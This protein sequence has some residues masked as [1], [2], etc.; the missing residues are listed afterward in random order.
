[1]MKSLHRLFIPLLVL[2][3]FA[4]SSDDAQGP[5]ENFSVQVTTKPV[6]DITA[7]TARS[8]GV[9]TA[10]NAPN[11]TERG[12]CWS[13]TSSP[14]VADAKT[15]DGAGLGEYASTLSGLTTGDTYYVRAYAIAGSQTFYGAAVSFTA[16]A[17]TPAVT[18]AEVT[19]IAYRTAVCGGTIVDEGAS[20][21]TACGICWSTTENPT[22]ESDNVEGDP[23]EKT[24]TLPME[25]LS[26]GT[27]YYVRA[28]ASNRAGTGYGEQMRFSTREESLVTIA[29]EAFRQYC[30]DRFDADYDGKLQASEAAEVTEIDCSDLGI[31]S[32]EGIAAFTNLRT[33][34][35]NDNPL[36]EIDVTAN[37]KL[38]RLELIRTGF[39]S[40]AIADMPELESLLCDGLKDN[41][42][43]SLQTLS[44]TGC[45]ALK[46]LFCQENSLRTLTLSNTPALEILRFNTN[47]LVDLDLS[48]CP[49]LRELYGWD[50]RLAALDL[51]ANKALTS[52]ELQRNRLTS[53]ELTDM[54]ELQHVWCDGLEKQGE[55]DVMG[56]LR[57]IR[58]ANCPKLE[59]LNCQENSLETLV[60]E[61]CPG[62]IRLGAWRNSLTSLDLTGCESLKTLQV[63]DNKL[64]G[65]TLAGCASLDLLDI[66]ENQL[67][68]L[69]LKDCVRLREI[70]L[71]G[72]R[73]LTALDLSRNGELQIF[74]SMNTGIRELDLSGHAFLT[75]VWCDGCGMER[76]RVDNCPALNELKCQSNALTSL[77]VSGCPKLGVLWADGNNLSSLDLS[78]CTELSECNAQ[79]N[80]PLERLNVTG[81]TGLK[82]L[83]AWDCGLLTL[84]LSTN[85]N[86]ELVQVNDNKLTSLSVRGSRLHD[87]HCVRNA[88]TSFTATD[89]PALNVIW[90]HDN[91]L[92]TLDVS[93]CAA[94]MNILGVCQPAEPEA[95]GNPLQTLYVAAGQTFA[96]RYI[97]STTNIVIR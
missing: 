77:T 60:L 96:E 51:S 20:E 40:L 47:G 3:L 4:C 94:Q 84:D 73:T 70:W 72:N 7:T 45:P 34:M 38:T 79:I 89:C 32:L 10:E 53:L 36:H 62:L 22:I 17:A 87:V 61:G 83:Q 48:G 71:Q 41:E 9:L 16:G 18:T 29:D 90:I 67:A 5:G 43:G 6:T 28:F 69:D 57:S 8:G 59:E 92:T 82:T 24:F 21:V 14:T 37:T 63:A 85:E 56:T 35:A 58:I 95:H 78:G 11:V 80:K 15:S 39:A 76:I 27:T 30:L 49:A 74:R 33:L 86:L 75:S 50:N 12:V 65:L 2:G 88:L 91:Q 44:I 54:P 64:T 23:A 19:E 68:S 13:K 1:M 52:V 31:A 93:Q 42:V 81:C 66:P 26:S 55:N 46:E 25:N 97:P